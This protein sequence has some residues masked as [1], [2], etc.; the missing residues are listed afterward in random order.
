MI[1]VTARSASIFLGSTRCAD[2]I[3]TNPPYN[4]AE[5]RAR[6]K[7]ALLRLAFLEGSNRARTGMP[8]VTRLV[9][10]RSECADR[11]SHEQNRANTQ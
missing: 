7:F 3:V 4:C 2:D 5:E 9:F 11:E 10:S 8:A 1:A 6:R